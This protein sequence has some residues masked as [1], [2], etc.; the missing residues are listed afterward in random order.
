MAISERMDALNKKLYVITNNLQE[1]G[2][3]ISAKIEQGF[4]NHGN[5][6]NK[7]RKEMDK[8]ISNYLD[9]FRLYQRQIMDETYDLRKYVKESDR[10]RFTVKGQL[11][12]DE[13]KELYRISKSMKSA[14]KNK[15]SMLKYTSEMVKTMRIIA[16]EYNAFREFLP[17]KHKEKMM[18]SEREKYSKYLDMKNFFS[19][20]LGTILIGSLPLFSYLSKTNSSSVTGYV[21]LGTLNPTYMIVATVIGAMILAA[22]AFLI[23]RKKRK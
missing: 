23:F 9:L 13:L 19:I 22:F 10:E 17:E 20:A 21:S 12:E 16:E 11:I 8:F 1:S 14:E 4:E 7:D 5:L 15:E 18:H 2:K 3:E 6:A